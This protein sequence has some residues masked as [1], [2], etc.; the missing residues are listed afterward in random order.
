MM[1]LEGMSL[2]QADAILANAGSE[3][4]AESEAVLA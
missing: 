1:N 2:A 3:A 4:V